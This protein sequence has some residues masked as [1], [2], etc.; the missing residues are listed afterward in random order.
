[1]PEPSMG[2]PYNLFPGLRVSIGDVGAGLGTAAYMGVVILRRVS[3]L[4][5]LFHHRPDSRVQAQIRIANGGIPFPFSPLVTEFHI[6]NLLTGVAVPASPFIVDSALT[7]PTSLPETAGDHGT[8]D[9][10]SGTDQITWFAVTT[11]SIPYWLPA[12]TGLRSLGVV[13]GCSLSMM[14]L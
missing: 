3:H 9:P 5:T 2:Q 10:L 4:P 8:D 6:V 14:T 7:P 11:P 13:A 12:S 1:M